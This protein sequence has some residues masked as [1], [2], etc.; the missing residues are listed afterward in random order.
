MPKY[1][2]DVESLYVEFVEWHRVIAPETYMGMKKADMISYLR[3]TL[4]SYQIEKLY[5]K[6]KLIGFCTYYVAEVPYSKQKNMYIG[7]FVINFKSHGMG[8]G[9]QLMRT[10]EAIAI[11]NKC[12]NINLT[13]HSNNTAL[14]FYRNLDFNVQAYN[15]TKV[16]RKPNGK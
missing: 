7:D 2:K 16:L 5:E 4:K 8:Y 1:D 13:V 14:M 6:K 15:M 3:E 12:E 9:T 10:M 11:K